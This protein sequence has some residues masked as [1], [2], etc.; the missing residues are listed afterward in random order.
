MRIFKMI[1]LLM[2]I[3]CRI[4]VFVIGGLFIDVWVGNDV[5]DQI[6]KVFEEQ[7]QSFWFMDWE[8]VSYYNWMGMLGLFLFFV[9]NGGNG[10]LKNV[11]GL[12]VLS[13]WLLDD[14]CVFSK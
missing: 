1:F 9:F 11:N 7:F 8:F 3:V 5:M 4:E 13:Y 2:I 14:L 10:E 6:L 12:V